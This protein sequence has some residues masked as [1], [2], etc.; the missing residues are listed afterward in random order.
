MKKRFLASAGV[1]GGMAL[2]L[3]SKLAVSQPPAPITFC[4]TY[5]DSPFCASGPPGCDL[6]HTAPPTLNLYGTDVSSN[7]LV[8][9]DRPLSESQ[10]QGGLPDALA[11]S[12]ELDSDGDGFSN[13]E[14][15]LAG[16]SP[17]DESAVPEAGA[18]PDPEDNS[19][20]N[21]CNFDARFTFR[22]VYLD[23]CGQSP[24]YEQVEAIVAIDG[25]DA[26]R[27]AIS[28]ELKGCFDSDHWLAK[29]GQLWKLAHDKIRPLQAI[30]AGDEG[31]PLPL[32]DYFDDYVE[33]VDWAQDFARVNREMMM[34]RVLDC[35]AKDKSLPPFKARLEAVNCHHNY[36][37][38]EV[39][40]GEQV[41]VTRKGAVRAG[42]GEM[43]IIPGSMGARSFIVRGKGNPESFHSCSHGAGRKMSR[44]KAKKTFSVEDHARATAHVECRKDEAV[45][46]E[47]PMAYKDIDRVMQAQSELVEIAHTL[48]QVVC[49][50]G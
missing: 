41:F 43:G 18:C 3:T 37:Q 29:D 49:V 39:H 48:R 44:T 45:I 19:A 36:V 22:K 30:K 31:G 20:Y 21:V 34:E 2:L 17:A 1:I 28:D 35:L 9:T 5:P 12:E 8:G 6:C 25:A 4:D 32:S 46:D 50:K 42:E 16:S 47:T 38:Q 7:L 11:A 14:E 33:A 27:T 26:Q 23:V 40:F 13:L 10:F 24:T 15:L